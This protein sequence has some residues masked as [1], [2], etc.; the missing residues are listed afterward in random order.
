MSRI[1]SR[2][3]KKPQDQLAVIPDSRFR[4]WTW[5]MLPRHIFRM[6]PPYRRMQNV[7]D[8]FKGLEQ[9]A[10]STGHHPGLLILHVDVENDAPAHILAIRVPT[11]N[12]R[13]QHD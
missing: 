9:T 11:P 4:S 10:R 6:P 3:S 2:E 1:L 13:M 12:R 5:R 8:S 7:M